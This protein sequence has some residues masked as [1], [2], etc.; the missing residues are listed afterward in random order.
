MDFP[1]SIT[2]ESM[3]GKI[4]LNC[5]FSRYCFLRFLHLIPVYFLQCLLAQDGQHFC[6][7]LYNNCSQKQRLEFLL[8]PE[9]LP[10]SE[11]RNN[12]WLSQNFKGLEKLQ[13]SGA[14]GGSLWSW[15]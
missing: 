11:C 15:V 5:G 3:F 14:T 9:S 10:L 8:I 7:E 12:H 6:F 4:L 2:T 1:I 13:E